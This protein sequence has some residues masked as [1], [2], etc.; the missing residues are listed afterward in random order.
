MRLALLRYQAAPTEGRESYRRALELRGTLS[1]RDQAFLAALGAFIA[2]QPPDA[3]KRLH[4]MQELATHYPLDAEISYQDAIAQASTGHLSG[5]LA[6]LEKA[7]ALDPKFARAWWQR[8][9]IL[10]YL[11]RL[12]EARKSLDTCL[13]ISPS[14]TSCTWNLIC[15]DEIEGACENVEKEA[16]QWV[17]SDG[18][19]PLGH[20]ALASALVARGRPIEAAMEALQQKERAESD[21]DRPKSEAADAIAIGFLS[22]DFGAVEKAAQKLD[23]LVASDQVES[24]H[25][26]SARAIVEAYLESGRTQDAVKYVEAYLRRREAWLPDPFLE[27]FALANDVFPLMLRTLRDAGKIDVGEAARRRDAWI[28][29]APEAFAPYAWIHGHAALVETADEAKKELLA[30]GSLGVPRYTPKSLAPAIVGRVLFLAG[31][32]EEALPMLERAA[33]SCN[34]LELPAEHTRAHYWLGR[35]REA[36]GNTPGACRAYAV[37][38]DR[39]GK[40]RPTSVT[41]DLA[42]ARMKSLGCAGP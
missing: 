21:A 35:A 5:E 12:D 13:E 14:A 42:R 36:Q 26:A 15:I 3:E 31:R 9:Q 22:G 25:F 23:Q 41:A 7:T 38:I 8:G 40:A 17:V 16:R 18:R 1:A 33:S 27:D 39:W 11:D 32:T 29:R 37:V 4:A 30:R 19:D 20:F 6:A 28:A 2:A 34:A 24:E 10:A